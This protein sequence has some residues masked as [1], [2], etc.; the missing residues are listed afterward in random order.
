MANNKRIRL[1]VAA[2]VNGKRSYYK[3]VVRSTGWTWRIGG[4]A[5]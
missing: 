4:N 5:T 1:M 2:T 3:P